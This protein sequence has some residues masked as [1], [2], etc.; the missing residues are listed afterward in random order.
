[1]GNRGVRALSSASRAVVRSGVDAADREV[2][3]WR[4]ELVRPWKAGRSGRAARVGRWIGL[5]LAIGSAI[6]GIAVALRAGRG[7]G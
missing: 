3:Y 2:S 4:D 1:M 6:A 5:G 7:R